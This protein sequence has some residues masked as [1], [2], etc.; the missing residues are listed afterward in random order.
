MRLR[1]AQIRDLRSIQALARKRGLAPEELDIARMVL[2]DP[3]SRIAICASGLVGSIETIV[4][5]GA[6]EVGASEPDLLIA[7][8]ELT[9]GL[10][11]LMSRALVSRSAS[12]AGREVA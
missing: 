8:D 11:E 6:I 9:D 3:R 12:I 1:L 10:E 2:S 5:F 4:G 7:D